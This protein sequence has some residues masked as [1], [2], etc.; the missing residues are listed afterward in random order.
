MGGR[1]MCVHCGLKK[2]LY[3]LKQG[4]CAWYSRID[5]YL[6]SLG[7]ANA[8]MNPNLHCLFDKSMLLVLVPYVDDLILIGSFEKFIEW[9]KKKLANE[10]DMKDI[11]LMH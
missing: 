1:P 8:A 3:E 9:C 4:P 10:F 11:G 5:E 2:T 7:F 6:L